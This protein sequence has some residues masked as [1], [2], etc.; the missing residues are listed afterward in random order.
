MLYLC[1]NDLCHND[2][3]LCRNDLCLCR[4]DLYLCRNDLYLSRN[5]LYLYLCH[6]TS[7]LVTLNCSP[8]FLKMVPSLTSSRPSS[9]PPTLPLSSTS[10]LTTPWALL[11]LPTPPTGR[12]TPWGTRISR[13]PGE[14]TDPLAATCPAAVG[15]GAGSSLTPPPH[16]LWGAGSGPHLTTPP[17]RHHD[18]HTHL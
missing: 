13:P 17:S 14:C 5:N 9:L 3:C 18:C 1:H 2:L 10:N 12:T 7:V 15:E 6:V 8:S 16:L 4:N 11:G